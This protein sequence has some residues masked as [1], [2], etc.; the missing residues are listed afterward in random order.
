LWIGSHIGGGPP[1]LVWSLESE[2][3]GCAV[4]PGPVVLASP[5]PV[6]GSVVASAV[7]LVP[8]AAPVVGSSVVVVG[9]AVVVGASVT[10]VVGSAVAAPDV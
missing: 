10:G 4:V 6:S 9:S 3:S 7:P 5:V 8:P 1:V 2:V